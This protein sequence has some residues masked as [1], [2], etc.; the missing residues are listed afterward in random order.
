MASGTHAGTIYALKATPRIG[1]WPVAAGCND[2]VYIM[3]DECYADSTGTAGSH[4]YFGGLPAGA[5]PL[6]S[7]IWPIDSTDMSVGGDNWAGAATGQ[8]GLLAL[9]GLVTRTA[10]PD[11]FGDVADLNA[12]ALP[13]VF[14]PCPDA[15]IYTSTLDMSLRTAVTPVLLTAADQAIDTEGLALK[16]LYTMG[17]RRASKY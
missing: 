3:A 6:I 11:L 2:K 10:D 15:T 5:M 7:V 13:R 1:T 8:L 9:T 12:S 14:E 16:M 4:F 17:N